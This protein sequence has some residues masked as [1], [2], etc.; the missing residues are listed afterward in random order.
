MLVTEQQA[1]LIYCCGPAASAISALMCSGPKCMGWRW[2]EGERRKCVSCG[3]LEATAEIEA[4][5]RPSHI[6]LSWT[7]NP[8]NEVSVAHWLEPELE[9]K[10]R[11][12][13][14][15]GCAGFSEWGE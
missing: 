4:G 3:N 12:L 2:Y 5:E 7:F 10:A 8:R 9:A 1:R 14:F 6:P 13:G 15:C 11:R